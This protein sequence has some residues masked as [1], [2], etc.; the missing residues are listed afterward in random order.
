M[1]TPSITL[2]TY[3]T[4]VHDLHSDFHCTLSL[5]ILIFTSIVGLIFGGCLPPEEPGISAP[6]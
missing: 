3:Y 6:K 5:Q 4:A 2:Y 1:R